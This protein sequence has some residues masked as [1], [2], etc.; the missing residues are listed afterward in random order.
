[1]KNMKIK[2]ITITVCTI[3]IVTSFASAVNTFGCNENGIETNITI[4]TDSE[5]IQP[6]LTKSTEMRLLVS[7]RSGLILENTVNRD[8]I[9]RESSV[10]INDETYDKIVLPG[11]SFTTEVGK[12]CLPI[13]VK[14]IAIPDSVDITLKILNSV[15]TTLDDYTIAP[16]PKQAKQETT[17]GYNINEVFSVDK[18]CYAND[19]FYPETIAQI[20]SISYMRD[21]RVARLIFYPVQYNP[22]LHEL[23]V[24]TSI[25]VHVEYSKAADLEI[26]DVGPYESMCSDLIVNYDVSKIPV[27]K[28]DKNSRTA[29]GVVSYPSDLSDP[30][31]A[32]D[33]LIITS[34]YFYNPAKQDHD[35]G[36]LDNTLNELA[37]WRAEYNGFNVAVINVNDSFIGGNT[38]TNIKAFIEYAYNHWSAPHMS[39]NHAGY[40]LLVG[41]TPFV[42]THINIS[43]QG[44]GATDRW[45]GCFR[46][47][48]TGHY[49][50]DDD[51]GTVDIMIGRFSVDDYNELYTNAEKTI[52][53]E[54]NPE[55]G[56]WQKHA[57]LC[58]GARD[59]PQPNGGNNFPQYNFICNTLLKSG[60]NLSEVFYDEGGTAENV[61]ENINDGR[62]IV[63]YCDHGIVGEWCYL[64]FNV[65]RIRQLTNARKLPLVYSL[66]CFTGCFQNAADCMGEEFLNNPHGGAVAFFGA[67]RVSSCTSFNFAPYLITSIFLHSQHIVGTI[68]AEGILQAGY[69]YSEYN[70]L[71]DPALNLSLELTFRADAQGPYTGII[72]YPVRC[73][74]SATGGVGGV[75]SCTWS[76][77]FGDGN[78]STGQNPQHNYSQA[79]EYQVVLTVT[80]SIGNTATNTTTATITEPEPL[81]SFAHGPYS[82]VIGQLISFSGGAGGGVPPYRYFWTFGDG[83]MSFGQDPNVQHRYSRAGR[84][85]VSLLVYDSYGIN[86]VDHTTATIT[87]PEPLM[88]Y[89]HGPYSGIVGQAVSFSGG[90]VGGVLLYNWSWDFG[91]GHRSWEQNS[92]HTYS[93]IGTYTVTLTVTDSIGETANNTTTVVISLHVVLGDMNIDGVVSW[94]DIDP[95]VLAMS[96]PTGYQNQY[97][98]S[99]TLHGDINQDGVVNWRDIEPFVA[100]LTG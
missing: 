56:E 43:N 20:E 32:A 27:E 37:H 73:T 85:S 29:P 7:D 61:V 35:A 13:Q 11:Y 68:I 34:D 22:V 70:L 71:G 95:F 2:T 55:P 53:Y 100:L 30:T 84:Y 38:D 59:F 39:D 44:A 62:N 88:A 66:A 90:A 17:D 77:D 57:L 93:A 82:G 36:T 15:Y 78:F 40:I 6:C 3:L 94:R 8:D 9:Q 86:A 54:K 12:P 33:Y 83:N 48:G 25:Q 51:Y 31:N 72:N 42:A 97:H 92:T 26:K 4:P 67:S 5:K 46:D 45:Y 64:N 1:M 49:V 89:A 80:D 74:G 14:M 23:K 24:Y 99:A 75:P 50:G 18:T 87:E 41:D 16:V 81:E 47:D 60:W 52:Q 21:Q 79:G 28:Q 58:E 96:D 19:V 91:D 98:I 63:V 76:W 65:N 69:G 10:Q